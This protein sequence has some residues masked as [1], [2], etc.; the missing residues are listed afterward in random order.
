M[1]SSLGRPV[2]NAVFLWYVRKVVFDNVELHALSFPRTMTP[3][4]KNLILNGLT[5]E[6][7]AVMLL[8]TEEMKLTITKVERTAMA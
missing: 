6:S 4:C 7:T 2:V 8:F 1:C 5:L 3:N